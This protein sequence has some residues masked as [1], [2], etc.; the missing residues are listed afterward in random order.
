MKPTVQFVILLGFLTVFV[1]ATVHN[2]LAN[3]SFEGAL[4]GTWF[5]RGFRMSQHG[6]EVLEGKYSAICTGRNNPI[7]GPGQTL[8]NLKPGGRYAFY[9]NVKLLNDNPAKLWQCF[10]VT[11]TFNFIESMPSSNTSA[12]VLDD[13]PTSYVIAYRGFVTQKQGWISLVGNMN[14]PVLAFR[15]VILIVRGPDSGVS[16]LVDNFTL[17]EV[18]EHPDWEAQAR[19]NIDRYRKSTAHFQVALPLGVQESTVDL[20]IKHKKHNFAFG[21]LFSDDILRTKRLSQAAKNAYTDLFAYLFNWAVIQSYKWK[22]DRG[23]SLDRP[24]YSSALN[25]T[26]FLRQKGLKVR[27][28]SILWDHEKNIPDW[29]L[30]VSPDKLQAVLNKHIQYMVNIARGKLEQWD[31]Q[32]EYLYGHY[33][34]E[35]MKDPNVTINA[36]KLARALDRT[37]KLYLNDFQAVTTGA[38]TEDFHDLAMRMLEAGTGLQGLGIQGHTKLYTKPDPTMMWKR[39]DRLAQTGLELFMTEFDVT[40]PDYVVRADWLE[41]AIRAFFAHPH[42]SGVILWGFWDEKF[43]EPNKHLVSGDNLEI[44]EPGQ[45]WACLVKKEWTTHVTQNLGISGQSFDVRG[46]QGD[47]EV[48]VKKYGVP[49]QKET[50]SLGKADGVVRIQV[51][52]RNV[53]LPV[54]NARDYVRQCISHRAQMTMGKQTSSS[55]DNNLSCRTVYTA[56]GAGEVYTAECASDEVLTGCSSYRKLQNGTSNGEKI[57]VE[58]GVAKCKVYYSEKGMQAVARCCK[59]SGLSCDYRTAGPSSA[60]DGAKAEATCLTGHLPLGCSSYSRYPDHDGGYPDFL[61]NS[62]LAQSGAPILNNPAERSG[63]TAYVVCC[64][65]RGLGCHGVVSE[66]SGLREGD[67]REISCPASHVMTGCTVYA[68]SGKASGIKLTDDVWSS[69]L[70]DVTD[71]LIAAAASHDPA[72]L[73]RDFSHPTV[74]RARSL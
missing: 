30:N 6:G 42:L 28:H 51:T 68:A 44:I 15:D 52:N 56:F 16:F 26:D 38:N 22:F 64:T 73:T 17:W 11:L 21:S 13:S 45:R 14:I 47:Y 12:S 2:L 71:L 48:I 36:F 27:G 10:K 50:F 67:Y 39:L 3:P 58:N 9:G 31:V 24:D 66:E 20:E 1:R 32:N 72:C 40:W 54:D 46:F 69:H 62:C 60:F 5:G 18:P 34:E 43:L 7:Q 19:I 65:A 41:D 29:V 57:V 74:I 4:K 70:Y 59:M 8:R 23:V 37:T 53:S 49:V 63:A 55:R 33:Y 61:R 25:A 35:K